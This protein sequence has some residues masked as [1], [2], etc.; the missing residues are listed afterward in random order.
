MRS[1]RSSV[2]VVA[3][4][5]SLALAGCSGDGA[6]PDAGRSGSGSV[7]V[8]TPTSA[9]GPFPYANDVQ[10]ATFEAFVD[11][12]ARHG[13][14]YEGPFADSTGKGLFLRLA[15]G[16]HAT[17]KQQEDVGVACPEF[18]VASFGTEVERIREGAFERAATSFA[19]CI[20]DHGSPHYPSPDF[21]DGD[22]IDA[23][24]RL[25]FQWSDAAFT[26]AV[27]SCIQPLKE[28]MFG[29]PS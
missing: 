12:A 26:R 20:R 19:R 15:S 27:R 7:P 13:I 18:S 28:Y 10:R 25:P 21:R 6:L 22:V 11:C 2:A 9:Y 17:H 23:F 4:A 3:L 24:W 14:R 5:G 16:E 1:G 8:V 29:S